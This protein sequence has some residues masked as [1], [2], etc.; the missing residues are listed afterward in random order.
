MDRLKHAL[1]EYHEHSKHRVN[2]YAPGPRELDWTNQPDPFREFYGTPRIRLPLAADTL[3]TRYNELRCGALPPAHGFDLSD[4]AILFELSLGLSAW[5]S[6]GAQRWALRC[7]PSSGNLHPTEG[8]LL[9]PALPGLSGGVYHYLSRDHLLER[10]AAVDDPRWTEAF[11]SNGVLVGI[12]SIHWREAWKYGMRAW[13]YCQHDCGHVIA[14][15]SY[16][17][18]AL[19]WQ[20]RLVEAAA[21]DAVANLLGLDRGDDFGVAEVEA[22][23]ALLWI[24]NSELRPDLERMLIALDTAQW[25]G[26]ANQL[27]PGH[28][29]WPQIDSIRRATHKSRTREPP[30]PNPERR[31]APPTPAL[32]LSFARIARQRRSAVN[33]DGTTRVTDAAFFSMLACLLTRPDTPPWNALTC[34]AAVHAA[35]LVH[36]VE[37]LEPGLYMLVRNSRALPDL[38]LSMRPEWLWLKA[39]PDPLPLYFLL[40]YDLRAAAKLICCHQDIGADSCFAL[41]MIARFEIALKQPWRYRHLFWECGMLGQTLYLEAEAAGVRATGIGC[42]FDDEM[43]ALLGMEDHTWQSLYHFTVGGAVDDLRL[44]AFPPYVVQP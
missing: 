30:P 34:P 5:K 25:H 11:S 18:A 4:V 29:R 17:A 44:S 19:G 12:S 13:R 38:K 8:Y 16:A 27:S 35:L 42:F 21:D 40:P 32:D 22:P 14:A 28:V 6:S 36:R 7:N 39:G 24:G 9:C 26:R 33:F 43:H 3:A 1:L 20:T 15:L 31:P 2:C 23:D 37:G 10:R 41:G